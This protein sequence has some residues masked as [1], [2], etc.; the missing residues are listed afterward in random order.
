MIAGLFITFVCVATLIGFI[1]VTWAY[2]RGHADGYDAGHDDGFAAARG[3]TLPPI[4]PEDRWSATQE[5]H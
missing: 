4:H 3:D 5:T 1:L 2:D